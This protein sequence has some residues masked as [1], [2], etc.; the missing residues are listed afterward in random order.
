MERIAFQNHLPAL[1]GDDAGRNIMGF[2]KK[3]QGL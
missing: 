2:T 3:R 1:T